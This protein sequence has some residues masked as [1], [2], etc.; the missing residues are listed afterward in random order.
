M[1]SKRFGI[2]PKL[3]EPYWTKAYQLFFNNTNVTDIWSWEID[4]SWAKTAFIPDTLDRPL[5]LGFVDYKFA[6]QNNF[7]VVAGVNF[8]FGPQFVKSINIG[9]S[10][11]QVNQDPWLIY[12]L[13]A[14]GAGIPFPAGGVVDN[15]THFLKDNNVFTNGFYITFE[16][17]VTGAA[18]IVGS[19][20]FQGFRIYFR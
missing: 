6:N 12:N 4:K 3:I 9:L 14:L 15:Y 2:K 1:F 18:S 20:T 8:E 7:T 16:T 10:S 5:F 13:G 11:V 17:D 19:F